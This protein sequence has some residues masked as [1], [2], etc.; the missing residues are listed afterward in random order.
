L[1]KKI[2]SNGRKNVKNQIQTTP[3]VVWF[4]KGRIRTTNLA[5]AGGGGPMGFSIHTYA[6]Y[7]VGGLYDLHPRNITGGGFSGGT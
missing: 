2:D 7:R 6:E 1:E 3:K 4:A 5:T